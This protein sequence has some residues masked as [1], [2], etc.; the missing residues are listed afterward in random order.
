M[1]VLD[2][3]VAASRAKMDVEY[4]AM[5]KELKKNEPPMGGRAART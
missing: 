5:V 2:A 3:A 1:N 4:K